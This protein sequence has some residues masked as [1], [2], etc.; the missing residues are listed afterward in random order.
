MRIATPAGDLFGLG[1]VLFFLAG[2]ALPWRELPDS[3]ARSR[4]AAGRR[5]GQ[6]EGCPGACWE[7]VSRLWQARGGLVR[8]GASSRQPP[9]RC[10]LGRCV[11][12]TEK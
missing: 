3:V 12:V 5:P 6:P 8:A 11:C 1:G 10:A 4:F 9:L 2:R 7:L